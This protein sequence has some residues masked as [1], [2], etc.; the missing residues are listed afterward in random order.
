MFTNI[1]DT[2]FILLYVFYHVLFYRVPSVRRLKVEE[3][4]SLKRVFPGHGHRKPAL[5][6]SKPFE[7]PG[8]YP[9]PPLPHCSG[10]ETVPRDTR[11]RVWCAVYRF[12]P[13]TG[14][15]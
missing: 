4:R 1:I 8:P 7:L 3:A 2:F 11:C 10:P 9:A 15:V 6:V 5:I 13:A 12:C 14:P